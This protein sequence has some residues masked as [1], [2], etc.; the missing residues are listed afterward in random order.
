MPVVH[1]GLAAQMQELDLFDIF[2][3]LHRLQ[4]II[5]APGRPGDHLT[6]LQTLLFCTAEQW[7]TGQVFEMKRDAQI[8][9][10][11]CCV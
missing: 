3:H 7:C 4:L 10:L 5:I 2:F 6:N 11:Q 9:V 8:C 1:C